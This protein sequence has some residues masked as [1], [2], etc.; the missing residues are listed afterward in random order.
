M[1]EPFGVHEIP[2]GMVVNANAT[3]CQLA[4]QS[5]QRKISF[6]ASVDQ[7]ITNF[8]REYLGFVATHLTRGNATGLKLTPEPFDRCGFADP[9]AAGSRPPRKTTRFDGG[10]N[11]FTQ[12]HRV[13]F[14]HKTLASNPASI[15]NLT[16]E[17]L[18]I[19]RVK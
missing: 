7:P 19:P 6:T 3:I 13:G 12:I 5:S 18:G 4:N 9:I 2:N 16:R 10:N 8:A 15:L 1:R 11:T 17:A 14:D